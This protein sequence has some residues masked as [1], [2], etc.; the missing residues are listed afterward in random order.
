MAPLRRV[1]RTTSVTQ[2]TYRSLERA[3]AQNRLRPGQPLVIA[4][5]AEELGVSRTPVREALLMLEKAGLVEVTNGRLSV[6]GLGTGDLDEVFEFREAIERY[7]V[8]KLA[9]RPD[10]RRLRPLRDL[11]AAYEGDVVDDPEAAAK[12]DLRFHRTV[13]VLAGNERMV[14]AWDQMATNLQRFWQDGRANV[15]RIRHDVH[16]CLA[17]IA[18]LET[19]NAETAERVLTDHL[20]QAKAALEAWRGAQGGDGRPNAVRVGGVDLDRPD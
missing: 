17:I 13:V 18:A 1:S 3:I 8:R 4:D 5:L 19:G 11:L 6:A 14:A 2:R 10:E 20:R 9:Q 16:E 12:A 7:C 15:N